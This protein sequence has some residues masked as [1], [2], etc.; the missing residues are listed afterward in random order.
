MRIAPLPGLCDAVALSG[1]DALPDRHVE[2]AAPVEIGL[3]RGDGAEG[4][5]LGT[6]LGDPKEKR[7]STFY[8]QIIHP[9]AINGTHFANGRNQTQN[10]K[11][12]IAD[13][14]GH[15]NEKCMLPGQP[16][17]NAGALSKKHSGL[18]FTAAEIEELNHI[19]KECGET[20]W[21][22]SDLKS[23]EV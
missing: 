16:E 3:D 22:L 7:A 10:V 12:I 9:D 17:A 8:F 18:L 20:L 6:A 5:Q 2:P 4:E 13:I 14:L 1:A 11:A 15:G 19:A 21:K 23:V